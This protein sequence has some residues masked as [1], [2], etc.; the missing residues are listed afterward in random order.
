MVMACYADGAASRSERKAVILKNVMT[1]GVSVWVLVAALATSTA[2]TLAVGSVLWRSPDS[3]PTQASLPELTATVPP[4]LSVQEMYDQEYRKL[5]MLRGGL[6]LAYFEQVLGVP[7]FVTGSPD[8]KYTQSLFR[9]PD[10]WVQAISDAWG[11]VQLMAVTSCSTDFHPQFGG[12]GDASRIGPA[13][14]LNL[15]HFNEVGSPRTVRYFTSG[16]TANSYYYDEYYQ[17]NPGNYITH[18]VGIDDACPST[19]LEEGLPFLSS[20][21]MN[22]RYDSADP[23]VA[24]FRAAAIANTYAESGVFFDEGVLAHFQIGAD[25]I[26]TRTAPRVDGGTDRIAPSPQVV[27]S[28]TTG[29]PDGPPY[30]IYQAQPGDTISGVATKFDISVAY[31]V[32]NNRGIEGSDR[33]TPG[34]S[35][36]VPRVNGILHQVQPGETLNGIAM[37]FGVEPGAILSFSGNRL[38]GSGD[39]SPGQVL[40]VPGAVIPSQ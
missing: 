24:Q 36:V 14:V 33:L 32:A 12:D 29:T 21:Y 5:A 28:P 10:Y 38:N 23:V 34:Q 1:T 39:I 30:A 16:A 37:T 26:L 27:V 4:T 8:G 13:V 3:A 22:R 20:A 15:T 19:P 6:S 17:G 11:A 9:G 31:L 2:A 40:L 35:L 25:R 18:F 7:M